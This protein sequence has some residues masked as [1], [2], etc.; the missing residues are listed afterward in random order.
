M[1]GCSNQSTEGEFYL[2]A[3][4]SPLAGQVSIFAGVLMMYLMTVIGNILMIMLVC[5]SPK[6][7][8]P[9]YFF[10]C[11]LALLDVISTS[12][13]IPKLLMITLTKDHRISFQSCIVQ[14]F[15]FVFCTLVDNFVLTSMAYDR[16]LAICKPLQY[17][18]L[19]DKTL[20]FS[21]SA[22]CWLTGVLNSLMHS[23]LTSMLSF[24]NLQDINNFFCDLSSLILLSSSDT[25]SRKLLIF[26]E[27]IFMALLPFL[28]IITSYVLI[29]TN[30]LK[31]RSKDG[32]L[33]SFSCCTSHLVTVV[34]FYG[35][36]II[37]Y[38]KGESEYPTEQDK[39][40][41]LLYL[42][43]VPM[44]NP[45]VYGLRNRDIGEAFAIVMNKINKEIS[46]NN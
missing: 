16:Y 44:L 22:S 23:I 28:L 39:L 20:C 41:S 35:P 36:I 17:Y 24:C 43:V 15:F 8:N 12:S 5:A 38:L 42:V 21:I 7:H 1:S 14:L 46:S 45:F 9:M 30:I 40:L 18:L 33:K 3:F 37:V 10:L 34:L 25:K 2:S 32:R 6:L 4:S 11:N 13:T 26:F 19:M 31:I 29:I 27:D